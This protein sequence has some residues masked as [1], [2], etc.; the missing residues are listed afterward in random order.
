MR[1]RSIYN[2]L[3]LAVLFTLL[4]GGCGPRPTPTPTETLP[5]TASPEPV[6]TSVSVPRPSGPASPIVVQRTPEPGAELA[7]D[8]AVELVFDRAMDRSSVESAFQVSPAVTGN[9]EWASDRTVRF[10]PA[11][12]LKRDQEYAVTLGAEARAADGERLEDAYR[13]RFR[14]VGYLEVSQAVPAPDSRDVEAEST[15][16]VMFNRPVVPLMAVSDPAY[17]GLPQPVILDPP[18]AG[19]GE[20][21]NTSIYAFTPD[22]A[23]AGGTTYTAR[24]EAGLEDTTGGLLDEAYEWTFTTQPPKVTWVSPQEGADLVSVEPIVRVVFNMPVDP[25]SVKAAFSLSGGGAAVGGDIE[26]MADTFIFTPT[27]QLAFDTA[28]VAR[29]DAGVQSIGGG[30]GMR[31]AYEWRFT[32]VPLPRIVGTSPRDGEENADPYQPFEIFFNAPIDPSTVMPNI[33]M[34]PPISPAL[35]YTYFSSYDNTFRLD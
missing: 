28:Y 2:V 34:T 3:T 24:V 9:L 4:V 20:W 16:T 13:F 30:E 11:R 6:P 35:S 10:K 25:A 29:I 19:Q 21:I 26:V 7:P 17:E 18:V 5:P 31:D 12:D 8:G 15:I 22:G 32:T 27:E 33:E 1:K 14:T 23:M